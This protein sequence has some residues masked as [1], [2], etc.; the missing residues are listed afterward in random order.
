TSAAIHRNSSDQ[1][2]P[3]E[4]HTSTPEEVSAWL[5]G[6]V[7][8]HFQLPN[9]RSDP[10][11]ERRYRITGVTLLKYKG[12]TAAS[13]T[14]TG[15]RARVSLLVASSMSAVVA[16]GDEVRSGRLTFHHNRDAGL[17]VVTW[18]NHGLSYALVSP[19][20]VSAREP[21]LVCHQDMADRGAFERCW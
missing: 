16:G 8:F 12:S 14:Y 13:V 6:K 4:L 7:P 21:C 19:L 18:S 10:S 3:P 9:R 17:R 2:L 15:S 20:A 1:N 11:L 5:A